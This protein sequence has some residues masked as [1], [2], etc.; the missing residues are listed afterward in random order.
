MVFFCIRSKR[1]DTILPNWDQHHNYA[2]QVNFQKKD[3]NTQSRTSTI[4]SNELHFTLPNRDLNKVEF[5]HIPIQEVTHES[6]LSIDSEPS[7]RLLN[8]ELRKSAIKGEKRTHSYQS[9][10]IEQERRSTLLE[11]DETPRKPADSML[12]SSSNHQKEAT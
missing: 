8:Q 5:K 12:F 9:L 7:H 10:E 1:G 3:L 6:V 4:H 11:F 2:L